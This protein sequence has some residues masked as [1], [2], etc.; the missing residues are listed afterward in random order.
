MPSPL[1]TRKKLLYHSFQNNFL[2]RQ[3]RGFPCGARATAQDCHLL[4]KLCHEE[5]CSAGSNSPS[6]IPA[7]LP[8][9]D[10]CKGSRDG[11]WAEA[12]AGL[13][14]SPY[15]QDLE[16][17]TSRS[18]SFLIQK[19]GAIISFS[20]L[21]QRLSSTVFRVA[22]IVPGAWAVL[23]PFPT[24]D[25]LEALPLLEFWQSFSLGETWPHLVYLLVWQSSDPKEHT[26]VAFAGQCS[27]SP[28]LSWTS[29]GTGAN[30]GST[31]LMAAWPRH[32]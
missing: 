17:D 3:G 6:S 24:P 4:W 20:T 25:L 19:M 8:L 5:S 21:L 13:G 23:F 30:A 7:H 29:S 15:E 26:V 28:K 1:T 18:L 31:L 11:G 32:W 2:E 14:F 16:P 10:C 22:K 27:E 9:C 12:R